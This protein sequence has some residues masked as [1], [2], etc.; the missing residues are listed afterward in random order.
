MGQQQRHPNQ[1]NDWLGLAIGN[2]RLHW[3]WFSGDQLQHCWDTS[4]LDSSTIAAL[5]QSYFDVR[6]QPGFPAALPLPR[7]TAPPVLW[8]ASVVPQQTTYWQGWGTAHL[9]SLADVPIAGLYATFGLDRALALWGAIVT[10]GAPVLVIDAGTAL[11][12]SGVDA[13]QH[14]VGGA[15]LPGVRTQ[16]HSLHH[17]TAALPDLAA[18]FTLPPRWANTTPDAIQSGIGYT[19][20]AGIQDF[21]A[22]WYQQFPR[23]TVVLTGGDAELLQTW[24]QQRAKA[25]PPAKILERIQRDAH[26]LVLGMKAIVWPNYHRAASS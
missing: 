16:F 10:Y 6:P 21:V 15:I 8:I 12:W 11:T 7:W 19:L 2:S 13:M 3:A 26:L 14:F 23:S 18:R 22:E 4:H 17:A 25:Q 9:L 24:L 1:H 5:W 20:V